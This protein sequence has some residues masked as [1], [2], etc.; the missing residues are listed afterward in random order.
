MGITKRIIGLAAG[1]AAICCLSWSAAAAGP[2]TWDYE[3]GGGEAPALSAGEEQTLIDFVNR[4][5]SKAGFSA[6]GASAKPEVWLKRGSPGSVE[7]GRLLP[8]RGEA[9]LS[10]AVICPVAPYADAKLTT[11]QM[12]RWPY[13]ALGRLF[14]DCST[15]AGPTGLGSGVVV[16]KNLVLTA[17][18]N[19]YDG[20]FTDKAGLCFSPAYYNGEG[21]HG[22]WRPVNL[23]VLT[24]Y[25]VYEW[26]CVNVGFMVM[27]TKN[28]RSISSLTGE[29]GL[30][31][32]IDNRGREF[33][34]L[35]YPEDAYHGEI[36]IITRASFALDDES[37]SNW[38][39]APPMGIG[40]EM[41]QG[42]QGGPWLT[43]YGG[44]WYVNGLT[45]YTYDACPRVQY[46]PFFGDEVLRGYREFD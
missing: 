21:P 9:E 38:S 27:E 44:E 3:I 18:S 7:T 39:C 17:A 43:E 25:K 13:T 1:L 12:K 28:G 19:I 26:P 42:A 23:G 29:I 4:A 33:F 2:I 31:V 40:G 8:P 46:S 35:G 15:D 11:S 5:F 41:G 10:P 32:N 37:E 34:T 45:A 36:P 22:T 20:A 24:L 30:A 6:A 14:T 16:G